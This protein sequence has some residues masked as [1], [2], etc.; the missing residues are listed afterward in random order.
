MG[1][2]GPTL[3]SLNKH[4]MCTRPSNYELRFVAIYKIN[5]IGLVGSFVTRTLYNS[6]VTNVE[7]SLL[8]WSQPAVSVT[9]DGVWCYDM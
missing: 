4:V 1:A 3:V 2:I 6:L 8:T 7:S 9:M 5:Y